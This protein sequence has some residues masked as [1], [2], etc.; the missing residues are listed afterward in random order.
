[1]IATYRAVGGAARGRLQQSWR[2]DA[3]AEVCA[4]VGARRTAAAGSAASDKKL[5]RKL[6]MQLQARLLQRRR[7]TPKR[8]DGRVAGQFGRWSFG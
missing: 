1:M 5:H 2:G 7:L 3:G 6:R 4:S 8:T